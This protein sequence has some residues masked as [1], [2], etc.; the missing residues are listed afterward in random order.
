[1]PRARRRTTGRCSLTVAD[2]PP[3]LDDLEGPQASR[4][5]SRQRRTKRPQSTRRY[6]WTEAGALLH[7]DAFELPK[8]DRRGHWA[9]GDRSEPHRT[10]QRG[11]GQGHRRHRRPHPPGLLPRST[12][13]RTRTT[14]SA[15]LRRA[16][17]WMRRAGLRPGAGGHDR[18]RQVLRDAAMSSATRSPSSAPATSSSRPAPRAGTGRSNGSSEPSTANGR[19]AASGP[20]RTNRDRALSSFIR[21][22]NRRRPH[23]ACRRPTA[24]HP[25]SAPPLAGQLGRA[26]AS[27]APT[28][29]PG[30]SAR[31][32][33]SS[34]LKAAGRSS[35]ATW[36]VSGQTTLRA[37]GISRANSSA[38]RG[39]HE[40]V[41]GAPDDQRRA[42][43][44]AQPIADRVVGER[45][46]GGHEA[47]LARAADLLGDERRRA[48][49]RDGAATMPKIS[50]RAARAPR[51]RVRARGQPAAVG[52]Q[53]VRRAAP[54]SASARSLRRYSIDRPAALTST[55][56]STRSG[57][58]IASS[59][60]MKPPIELPTTAAL[61]T[62][63]SSSSVVD[64]AR[65][66][67]RSRSS[68]RASPSC[69]SRAGRRRSRGAR[70]RRPAAAPASSATSP[71][72]RG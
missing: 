20:T 26:A 47:G 34:A 13:P 62:P 2:R 35:M 24:H 7:I 54:S 66:S 32:A 5:V 58:R 40:L 69:R 65:R 57:K 52:G 48:A 70:A 15:T 37:L 51:E 45:V 38:S 12:P 46:E 50:R 53:A 41:L 49:A 25:R 16:A 68:A 21:F 19:T 1:M 17:A 71:T 31:N 11:Q 14:V 44:L 59:M 18:Q 67:R 9:H 55:S 42:G 4:R 43:D 64:E 39:G 30:S 22:Y 29:S 23:T 60:P 56:R 63:S 27:C 6:E 3:S 33:S 61:P 72:G 10:R 8:F 28:R 36:P